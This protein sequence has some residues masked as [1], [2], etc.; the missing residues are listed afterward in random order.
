MPFRITDLAIN[1]T[2][3]DDDKHGVL[4]IVFCN[5]PKTLCPHVP[6]NDPCAPR[7]CYP[8]RTKAELL[9]PGEHSLTREQREQLK[10]QLAEALEDLDNERE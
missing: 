10:Q 7:T 8:A 5:S 2:Y 1:V 4:T 6:P 3:D 9:L